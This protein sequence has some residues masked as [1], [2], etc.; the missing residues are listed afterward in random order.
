MALIIS[1]DREAGGLPQHRGEGGSAVGGC[2]ALE[3]ADPRFLAD[4]ASL[5]RHRKL[6][7]YE[8]GLT[9]EVAEGKMNIMT[10]RQV[11]VPA[12]ELIEA[13]WI[14]VEHGRRERC[15]CREF[16]R[17]DRRGNHVENNHS[18]G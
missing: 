7:Q 12:L 9:T 11:I 14:F 16:F 15:H 4:L 6:D 17:V 1:I 10:R 2:S 13:L 18:C 5:L 8:S 3:R